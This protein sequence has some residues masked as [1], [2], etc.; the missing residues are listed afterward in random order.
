MSSAPPDHPD[1][2][3]IVFSTTRL[4]PHAET[5]LNLRLSVRNHS[6]RQTQTIRELHAANNCNSIP[7]ALQETSIHDRLPGLLVELP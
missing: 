2:S 6:L 5:I 7:L 4:F 3:A 1:P